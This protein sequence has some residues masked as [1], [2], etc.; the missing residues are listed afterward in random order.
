MSYLYGDSTQST[1]EMNYIEFL[2]D[3]MDL[4]VA[5]LIADHNSKTTREKAST[6]RGSA[7]KELESLHG[8]S[9][10]VTKFLEEAATTAAVTG[11]TGRCAQTIR[12]A[13]TEAIRSTANQIKTNLTNELARLESQMKVDRTG[14]TKAIETFILNHDLPGSV[15]RL[16]FRLDG[17][18]YR[19]RL[20][21]S[22]KEALSWVV[23]LEVPSDNIFA[24]AVRVDRLVDALE[25]KVPEL[26]GWVRKS[27]KLQHRKLTTKYITGLVHTTNE[28][29]LKLRVSPTD[30]SGFDLN[31]LGNRARLLF[32]GKE[33]QGNV[34]PFEPDAEDSTKLIEL[35]QL[36]L[37]ESSAIRKRRVK[38]VDARIDGKALSE[39]DNPSV[40]VQRLITRMAPTVTEIAKHSLSPRELVLKRV[41]A[42][43]RREEIFVSKTDLIAK[44]EKVPVELRGMFAPLG[45]GDLESGAVRAAPIPQRSRPT[46]QPEPAPSGFR[47]GAV[48]RPPQMVIGDDEQTSLNVAASIGNRTAAAAGAVTITAEAAASSVLSSSGASSVLPSKGPPSPP[49]SRPSLPPRPP[50]SKKPSLTQPGIPTPPTPRVPVLPAEPDDADLE[51]NI[52]AALAALESET[53]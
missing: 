28:S 16:E 15:H 8:F 45:L 3:A 42:N 32:Q 39:H 27:M 31:V 4:M 5:V 6:S 26:S 13:S 12:T 40:L 38:L 33:A 53:G 24:N 50:P 2:R 17:D 36:A 51:V 10:K 52:D 20:S 22:S 21:G 37:K 7:E 29:T 14:C 49:R 44:I 11:P 35:M 25:V 1:V 19:A 34:E 23:D 47:T 41:L 30:D 48:T 18:Q 46:I 9:N 43:D